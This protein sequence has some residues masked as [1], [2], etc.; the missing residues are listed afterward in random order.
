MNKTLDR[1]LRAQWTFRQPLTNPPAEISAPVS[2]LFLWRN[3]GKW[4]TFFE[5]TDMLGM[6]GDAPSQQTGREVDI[7]FFD[8]AGYALRRCRIE[9]PVNRRSTIRLSEMLAGIVEPMGTFCVL[10][11]ETPPSVR[12]LGCSLAERGY[13]S[14][15]YDRAPLRNYVHG[16]LDA[17]S[18]T[19]DGAIEMLAGASYRL[20][21]YRLQYEMQADRHY[22]IAVVNASA[23][24]QTI[25]CELVH[26]PS[27][28][29][30]TL[31]TDSAVVTSGGC[32][33]FEI[34]PE[35]PSSRLLIKSYL[36]M[37]RPLVFSQFSGRVDVFHG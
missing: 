37:A 32:H 20:R 35:V 1:L 18:R 3:D 25:S 31:A 4:E 30:E 21:E 8:P 24:K 28:V 12:T 34:K 10:H 27:G 22:E 9:A 26:Y 7:V 29:M 6:F 33:V 16:N 5:L 15:R 14:Y 2:D 11:Q 36:V 23:K 17:V 19:A 13:V